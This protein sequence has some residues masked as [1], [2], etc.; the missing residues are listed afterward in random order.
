MK[1]VKCGADNPESAEF[2]SLCME[3]LQQ[4]GAAAPQHRPSV[5]PGDSY[6]APGEW[7]GD[8]ETLSPT[9][10]KVVADKVM[11]FRLKMA[12][13]GIII[14]LLIAWLVLSV[15][16]WGNPS[17]GKTSMQLI[18][19]VNARDPETF[20]HLFLEQ[21]QAAA[22]DLYASIISYIGSSG[23]YE[24]ITLDVDQPDNYDAYSY[25]DGGTISA[26]A[27]ATSISRSDNLKI[28]L[29]NRGGKWYVTPNGTDLIP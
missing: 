9:V 22:E 1:C 8:T 4:G 17:P 26:A 28:A 29:E 5:V 10:S 18:D 15:T 21:N 14:A 23:K 11:R 25:L 19:A 12:I 16:L 24:D 20:V 3:K 2:C 6:L 13:Y 27:S 7:R